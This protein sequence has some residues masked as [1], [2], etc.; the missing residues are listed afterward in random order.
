MDLELMMMMM[1]PQVAR[2]AT[3]IFLFVLKHISIFITLNMRS[4]AQV[5][6]RRPDGGK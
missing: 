2:R 3:R 5:P 4:A 1:W 6:K